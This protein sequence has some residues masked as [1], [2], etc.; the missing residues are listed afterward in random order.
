MN[1]RVLI[2][3]DHDIV[4]AGLKALL[5]RQEDI[6]IVGEAA[7]G[8][9]AVRLAEELNPSLIVMD[10][11][12]PQLNGIDAAAQILRR[13]PDVRIIIL[14]MYADEEFL[15]RALAAG[16]KGYLLKDD[17]QADLLRAVR[18]VATGRSFFSPAIAQAL[19]EDYVRQLQNKGLQDSYELLSERERE[20]LQLLAEGKS[21][22]EAAAV[23]DVSPYT[24]ETHR[25]HLMQKLN[26]HNTAEI[27]LY[28]VRKK[29]VA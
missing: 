16:V 21:N 7:D 24:V 5:A 4:R 27:V 19:A 10:I 20:I 2:A 3:D 6:D 26:L 12:M 23:L 11:A 29:I 17:V 1:I 22:K 8:R 9:Q 15:V 13:D 28:A 18:A 25:T 14:S